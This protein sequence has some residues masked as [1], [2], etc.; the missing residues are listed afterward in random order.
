MAWIY[1]FVAVLGEIVWGLT[2]RLADGYTN[3]RWSVINFVVSVSNVIT[4]S[5]AMVEIPVMLAYPI[6][7]G[8]GAIGVFIGAIF[9]FG[10]P[11]GIGQIISI[12]LIITG[13]IG[14]R[15]FAPS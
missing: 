3:V 11:W 9:L 8:L 5:R 6:W 7:I 4:L 10:E 14:L 13:V 1:L 2:L 12:G 15:V